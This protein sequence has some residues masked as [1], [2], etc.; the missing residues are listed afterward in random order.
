LV[1]RQVRGQ[2]TQRVGA[3]FEKTALGCGYADHRLE[4]AGGSAPYLNIT[5]LFLGIQAD[6]D[7]FKGAGRRLCR[8]QSMGSPLVEA[9][10]EKLPAARW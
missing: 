8:F 1:E 6:V 5:R 3:L 9:D 7:D 2:H 10:G 4:G